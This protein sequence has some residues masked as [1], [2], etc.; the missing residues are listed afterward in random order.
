MSKE[1]PKIL[2][3]GGAGFI[4]SHVVDAH[5]ARGDDVWAVDNLSSGKRANV[6]DEAHF[7]E[8][9][10]RDPELRNLFREV[11]FDLVNHH[12][13]QIDVRVSVADPV[14]DAAVNVEG[15]LNV[16]EAALEVGTRRVVFVSSGGVVYGEPTEIPTPESASDRDVRFD[17]GR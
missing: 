17:V 4:G 6:S 1:R 9:D 10:I 2:V 8:M 7:V 14:R 3:T 15:L 12:A 16:L 11:R 5:L 13:A